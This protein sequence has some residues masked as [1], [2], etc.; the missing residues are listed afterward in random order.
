MVSLHNNETQTK[1][2]VGN[3]DWGIAEIGLT[4]FFIG[5]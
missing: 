1:T 4:V 3:R 5:K 2:E